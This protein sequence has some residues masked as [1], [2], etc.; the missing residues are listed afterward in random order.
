MFS[1][2]P[3]LIW[4]VDANRHLSKKSAYVHSLFV[5]RQYFNIRV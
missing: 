5:A 2:F 1:I 4:F 3:S